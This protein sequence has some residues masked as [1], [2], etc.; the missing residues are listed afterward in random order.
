MH[1]MHTTHSIAFPST[2]PSTLRWL[3]AALLMGAAATAQAHTDHAA[4]GFA[5]GFM[6]PLGGLDHLLAMLAV[7][8]WAASLGRPMVWALPVTFPVLMAVGGVLGMAGLPL[9]YV[10]AGI[11]VSVVVLG[12]V[13]LAAWHAP[14]SVALLMV[15]IFGVL[16]GY[17]HGAELPT[18]AE[19][20]AYTAGFVLATA[21]LHLAGIAI[22][23]L[24]LL[25]RGAQAL[26]AGGAAMAAAGV[27]ILLGVAGLV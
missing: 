22:G 17:A 20:G 15:G 10:E 19:P 6:H 21:L 3:M 16:H 25:P 9:P 14:V 2:K 7:G 11:A 8:V 12:L 26:R 1:T 24:Q 27:W 4:G 5:D 23:L 18:A 13:I